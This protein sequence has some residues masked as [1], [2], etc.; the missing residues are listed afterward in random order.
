MDPVYQ[1][2]AVSALHLVQQQD[3]RQAEQDMALELG[4][5]VSSPVAELADTSA[6]S[7]LAHMG[8][9]APGP[10]A[11]QEMPASAQGA[12]SCHSA[13][14]QQAAVPDQVVYLEPPAPAREV[15]LEPLVL[16]LE[17]PPEAAALP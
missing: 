16:D 5:P 10:F 7:L 4:L 15:E 1:V 12:D 9:P 8:A 2:S 17:E 6:P 13:L 14:R 11:D 3:F